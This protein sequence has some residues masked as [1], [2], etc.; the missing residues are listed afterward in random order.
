MLLLLLLLLFVCLLIC[1]FIN[2]FFNLAS[3]FKGHDDRGCGDNAR[4][5]R[6]KET[7]FSAQSTMRRSGEGGGGVQRKR[8]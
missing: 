5:G 4:G 8:Q 1:L 6:G 2:L 3:L 7:M